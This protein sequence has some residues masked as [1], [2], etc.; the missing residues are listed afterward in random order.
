MNPLA[1]PRRICFLLFCAIFATSA[2]ADQ[3]ARQ[4]RGGWYPW[5]PYQYEETHAGVQELTGLDI[6]LVPP[7]LEREGYDVTLDKL[8]WSRHLEDIRN[9]TRDFAMGAYRSPDRE[10]F[11][12]FSL[13]YRTETDVL[14]IMRGKNSGLPVSSTANLVAE[15]SRRKFRLGVVRGNY[16][17]P[18]VSRFLADPANADLISYADNEQANLSRLVEGKI[19]GF[20][21]DRLAAATMEWRAGLQGRIVEHPLPVFTADI[22]VMFSKK[23]CSEEMVASFNK[24]LGAMK[25][26]GAYNLAIRHYIVPVLLGITVHE[27]W[28]LLLDL[29]GTIAFAISGVLLAR[30]ERYDIFGAFVLAA[31]PAVGG[32]VVRDLIS[33]REPLSV[34]RSPI[35]LYAILATVVAGTIF[36]KIRDAISARRSA[37]GEAKRW[38]LPANVHQFFD[39]LGLAAFTII[40]VVVAVE[41]Q[42]DPLWL[43]GTLFAAITGAGGGILRDMVRA[44]SNNPSLKGSF[45]P[46]VAVIWGFLFSLFLTWETPRLEL[47][48]VLA[49]VL[50]AMFGALATRLLVMR[51]GIQSLFL[52]D[53]RRHSPATLL[54]KIEHR[55]IR[56]LHMLQGIVADHRADSPENAASRAASVNACRAAGSVITDRLTRLST[57]R[58]P[59]ELNLT[60]LRL[61]QRQARLSEIQF[62]LLAFLQVVRQPASETQSASINALIEVLDAW[63][64]S[65]R[66]VLEKP[67]DAEHLA[68]LAR[69]LGNREEMLLK[70]SSEFSRSPE[71]VPFLEACALF[72]RIADNIASLLALQNSAE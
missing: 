45:Y 36:Y 21:C 16:Y 56:W 42:C 17:G 54:D 40:G 53:V 3:P 37:S 72:D 66:D 70:R 28:F 6:Q 26:S 71:S 7:L 27:R 22:H 58:L 8:D 19:D 38:L 1:A 14:T 39:A 15:F 52:Y 29:V 18:D 62:D 44:D 65:A 50:I 23:T 20:I 13:P 43:W 61:Q 30:R 64:T 9:G 60:Y 10:E 2:F 24:S 25:D 35:Y 46:E 31:L 67:A 49:G 48:E 57:E 69:I 51:Y 32:S 47:D 5:D 68:L 34:L 12:W 11:A 33:G 41:Q 63:L 55:Q 59:D 4:L